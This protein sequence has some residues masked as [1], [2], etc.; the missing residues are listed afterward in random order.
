[1][2]VHEP[3]KHAAYGIEARHLNVSIL[4]VD[5]SHERVWKLSSVQARKAQ[6]LCACSALCS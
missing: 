5:I 6:L 1:M 4:L 2:Q 3:K